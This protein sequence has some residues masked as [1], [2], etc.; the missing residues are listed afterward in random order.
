M[1]S[2]AERMIVQE[3]QEES[4]IKQE[5]IALQNKIAQEKLHEVSTSALRLFSSYRN[6]DKEWFWNFIAYTYFICKTLGLLI[7]VDI[8]IFKK[9]IA[10]LFIFIYLF[11]YYFNLKLYKAYF[12]KRSKKIFMREDL[13]Q[14]PRV[15]SNH[16]PL[17]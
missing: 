9:P 4:R 3:V 11:C 5:R 1:G 10:T 13:L 8:F 15:D 17:A 16:E 14:L 12:K 2:F 7:L 6:F